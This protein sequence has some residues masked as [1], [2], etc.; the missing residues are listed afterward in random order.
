MLKRVDSSAAN[1]PYEGLSPRI[2]SPSLPRLDLRELQRLLEEVSAP[3]SSPSAP[4]K[5]P[6][7]PEKEWVPAW[8]PP[9]RDEQRA[10]AAG[11]LDDIFDFPPPRNCFRGVSIA[12][13]SYE[14]RP[15]PARMPVVPKSLADARAGQFFKDAIESLSTAAEQLKFCEKRISFVVV[16]HAV[17]DLIQFLRAL[18][19]LGRVQTVII[20]SSHPDRRVLTLLRSQFNIRTDIQRATLENP[21]AAQKLL[22][23]CGGPCIVVDIGG[24]FAPLAGHLQRLSQKTNVLG[25]VEDTQN[26]HVAYDKVL[27]EVAADT[28]TAL[29]D[30]NT[31]IPI[32]SVARSRIKGLEDK[33]VGP[34]IVS[35]AE[36]ILLKDYRTPLRACSPFGV[37]GCGKIGQGIVR[38]LQGHG[39]VAVV[40]IDHLALAEAFS[41]KVD[42][43][44]K[45]ELLRTSGIVFCATGNTALDESDYSLLRDN[46]FVVLATSA[47]SE[48]GTA[49][50]RGLDKVMKPTF[51]GVGDVTTMRIKATGNLVHFIG[52]GRAANFFN[53]GTVHPSIYAVQA[54]LISGAL[55]IAA[56]KRHLARTETPLLGIAAQTQQQIARLYLKHFQNYDTEKNAPDAPTPAPAPAPGFEDWQAAPSYW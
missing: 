46:A 36:A 18:K 40:D 12:G 7:A 51:E 27:A 26:G 20:K 23:E 42:A 32:V 47:D 44:S 10:R 4:E 9:S 41:E 52:G 6:F 16:A 11:N 5:S 37:I 48:L 54:A 49:W 25:I 33:W 39:P 1:S 21:S 53:G 35:A 45:A 19:Q 24:Y 43:L 29:I 50:P 55:G 34:A 31:T 30:I 28:D 22:D 8:P 38:S 14:N 56:A 13:F 15:A 17:P 3:K 2:Q